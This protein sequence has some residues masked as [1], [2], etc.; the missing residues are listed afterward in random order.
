[1]LLSVAVLTLCA[2]M[3]S[4]ATFREVRL[5]TEPSTEPIGGAQESIHPGGHADL[6]WYIRSG[7]WR[8][9]IR[10]LSAAI[11]YLSEQPV[12]VAQTN[13][14]VPIKADNV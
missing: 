5:A 3:L 7:Q 12:K 1:M 8:A 11:Q 2:L 9:D 14:L 4:I 6:Q 10:S 13:G